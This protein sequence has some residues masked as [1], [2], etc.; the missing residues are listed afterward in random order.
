[1]HPHA[2]PD[3]DSGSHSRSRDPP[4]ISSRE[5][6]EYRERDYMARQLWEESRS[7][8]RTRSS[9]LSHSRHRRGRDHSSSREHRRD[10]HHR[11]RS[12]DRSHSHPSRDRDRRSHHKK[13]GSSPS[14]RRDSFLSSFASYEDY[15][16]YFNRSEVSSQGVHHRS[17]E[18]DTFEDTLRQWGHS[19]KDSRSLPPI[20]RRHRS[21][22]P[23]WTSTPS[24]ALGAPP[25][26]TPECQDTTVSHQA[27]P[28]RRS[29]SFPDSQTQGPGEEDKEE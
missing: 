5:F 10:R 21:S 13:S 8:P 4:Y 28:D 24:T 7:R 23:Q 27:S 16:D 26:D 9:P 1:M 29:P 19:Y 2:Y 14:R 25:K 6:Q 3:W 12:K 15:L 18:G 17:Q 11:S 20:P 22:S